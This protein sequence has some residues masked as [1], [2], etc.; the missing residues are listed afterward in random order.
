MWLEELLSQLTTV[1]TATS[2]ITG[3]AV[4]RSLIGAFRYW[5]SAETVAADPSDADYGEA[6]PGEPGALAPPSA[7]PPA[8]PSPPKPPNTKRLAIMFGGT[9]V[10]FLLVGA[11]AGLQ[12]DLKAG[13]AVVVGFVAAMIWTVV[14]YYL[15]AE[16]D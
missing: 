14:A 5:H 11:Q 1:L 15:L 12:A 8:A 7:S 2:F 3:A 13:I 6:S 9:I 16:D 10:M 4:F